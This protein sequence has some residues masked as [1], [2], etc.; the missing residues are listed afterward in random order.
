MELEVM[1]GKVI[2]K[3]RDWMGVSQ[4]KMA[5]EIGA[6]LQDISDIETGER[7]ASLSMLSRIADYFS[8]GI[9]DLIDLADSTWKFNENTDE[10]TEWL[11]DNGFV[12]TVILESPNF[13]VA[14]SGLTDEG[15]LV[16]SYRKMVWYL[17]MH[18]GMDYETAVEFIDYNTL[19][20]LNYM[21]P[22]AP[23]VIQDVLSF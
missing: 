5:L 15:R 18:D 4:E 12:D 6:S 9:A 3:L 21:G 13:L 23:I 19:G 11:R 8:L 10:V 17:M 14:I 2:E 16:F 1:I 20:A 7:K 22:N